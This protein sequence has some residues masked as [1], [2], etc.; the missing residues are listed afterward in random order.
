[1][2][3]LSGGER[4]RVLLAR[5]LAQHPRFLI[6]DEPTAGVDSQSVE[7]LISLL[8]KLNKE[9]A[10]TIIMVTHDIARAASAATRIFCIEER[11]LQELTHEQIEKEINS[12]HIHTNEDPHGECCNVSL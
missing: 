11:N 3:N 10:L 9:N 5:A 2:E 6:L 1:M 8:E 4:Q 12:K 7:N